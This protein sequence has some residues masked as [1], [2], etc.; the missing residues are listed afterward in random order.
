[1]SK[2]FKSVN[3]L[4]LIY[5]IQGCKD[6]KD[7][8]WGLVCKANKKVRNTHKFRKQLLSKT[9]RREMKQEMNDK[10]KNGFQDF[11]HLQIWKN[12]LF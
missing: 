3:M 11:E 10:Q 5:D 1:M 8:P 2:T 7:K 9:R 6:L 4:S 12:N